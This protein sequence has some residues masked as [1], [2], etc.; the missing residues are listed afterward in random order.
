MTRLRELQ[1]IERGIELQALRGLEV[2]AAVP[3]GTAIRQVGV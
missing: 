3:I 1:R 2:F